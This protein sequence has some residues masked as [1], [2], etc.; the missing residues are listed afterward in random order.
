MAY[1][2]AR[3]RSWIRETSIQGRRTSIIMT[4]IQIRGIATFPRLQLF[5]L[6]LG[7]IKEEGGGE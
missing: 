6:D 4:D 5:C 3:A 7:G 2:R 1:T